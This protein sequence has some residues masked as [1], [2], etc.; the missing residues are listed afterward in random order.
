[1]R[2]CFTNLV[3][4]EGLRGQ[5]APRYLTRRFLPRT[6]T[7]VGWDHSL[8]SEQHTI[9]KK[10]RFTNLAVLDDLGT[11]VDVPILLD[12]SVRLL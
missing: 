12:M 4:L 6:N 5:F 7:R 8:Q 2:L 3:V 1:M 11:V 9:P 10:Q